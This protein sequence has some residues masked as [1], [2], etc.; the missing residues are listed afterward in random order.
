MRKWLI[1]L[2]L[3]L[4]PVVGLAHPTPRVTTYLSLTNVG[5]VYTLYEIPLSGPWLTDPQPT[6]QVKWEHDGVNATSFKCVLDAGTPTDLGLPT[7]SGT[8]YS[9]DI[10]A[11][12]GIMTNGS[13]SVVIQ[14]CNV[15]GCTSATA[16]TVVKL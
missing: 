11:C 9:V 7:P 16:I 13:H 6:P 14:A 4:L 15:N 3:L 1:V 2:S 12:T 10:T 8:T 5:G